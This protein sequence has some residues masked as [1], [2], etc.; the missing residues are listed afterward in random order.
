MTCSPKL[1][2]PSK[3]PCMSWSLPA[4]VTCPGAHDANGNV[5]PACSKCYALQGHY[6]MSNVEGVR[7]HNMQDWQHPGWVGAMR[8]LLANETHFRWFDS[9]DV[10]NAE[11]AAKIL[12]VC[13]LTPHV[14]HWLPTRARK[15][16]AVA[17]VL[18]RLEQLPNVVV[19][20]SSDGINGELLVGFANT[21]TI[22]A[23]DAD[24]PAGVGHVL[25]TA[26]RRAGKCGPCRACWSKRV[27]VTYYP[28]HGRNVGSVT[29]AKR[30]AQR[31]EVLA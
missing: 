23:S 20:H 6:L 14:K 30:A 29:I 27:E 18:E 1:S 25:C 16:A 4:Y 9:G 10:Y 2:Q 28:M 15:D 22:V 17:Q 19:R 3:M 24:A 26:Y 7:Q 8:D 13:V 31:A 12:A 11:L 21:S 5:V